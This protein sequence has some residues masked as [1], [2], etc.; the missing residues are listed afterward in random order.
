MTSLLSLHAVVCVFKLYDLNVH[1]L[2]T[3]RK[4]THIHTAIQRELSNSERRTDDKKAE[5]TLLN[6]YSRDIIL[7]WR[8]VF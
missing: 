5:L 4:H 2:H 8:V 1:E 7:M 6:V 3:A